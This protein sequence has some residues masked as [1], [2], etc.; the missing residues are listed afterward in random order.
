MSTMIRRE[1]RI[2]S[3]D[4]PGGMQEKSDPECPGTV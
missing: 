1:A 2:S 4:K 3:A